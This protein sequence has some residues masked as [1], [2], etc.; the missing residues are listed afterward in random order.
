[1]DEKGHQ[2]LV[3]VGWESFGEEIG[4]VMLAA[5]PNHFEMNLVHSVSY[6]VIAHV[7]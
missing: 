3:F 2:G 5:A 6:P 1:M 7:Y 4:E